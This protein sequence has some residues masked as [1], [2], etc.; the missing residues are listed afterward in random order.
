[1][2]RLSVGELC[3]Y[4]KKGSMELHYSKKNNSS[5]DSNSLVFWK[6]DNPDCEYT[7]PARE[8]EL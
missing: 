4:C 2:T 8:D 5:N 1:M 6:C 3:V 7:V